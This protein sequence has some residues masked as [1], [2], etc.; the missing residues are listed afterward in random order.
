M[1]QILV[2]NGREYWC[3]A[4][5]VYHFGINPKTLYLWRNRGLM[6]EPIKIGRHR[7]YYREDLESRLA[8]GEP[9]V[10]CDDDE[11]DFRESENEDER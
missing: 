2:L 9:L 5:I 1:K 10:K 11:D 3:T 7:F 4:Q 6:P 8:L